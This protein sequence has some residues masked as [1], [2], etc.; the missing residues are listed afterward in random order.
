MSEGMVKPQKSD[1]IGINDIRVKA[2]MNQIYDYANLLQEKLAKIDEVMLNAEDYIVC[3]VSLNM[4]KKFHDFR[5]NFAVV[6]GNVYSYGDDLG[7]VI[8]NFRCA[9]GEASDYLR[10]HKKRGM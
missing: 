10:S 3:D 6:V 5:T 4:F 1:I 8:N 2:A 7:K 9:D